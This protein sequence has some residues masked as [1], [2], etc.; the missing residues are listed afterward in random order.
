[1]ETFELYPVEMFFIYADF[2]PEFAYRNSL[3]SDDLAKEIYADH[4]EIN[5]Y[6]DLAETLG[7]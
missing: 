6:E 5:H 1:M 4:R 3:P 2:D 7:Y